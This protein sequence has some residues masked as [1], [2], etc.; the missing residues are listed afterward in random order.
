MSSKKSKFRVLAVHSDG[1]YTFF[2]R[3][4]LQ[5]C[6]FFIRKCLVNFYPEYGSVTYH[7]QEYRKSLNEYFPFITI[8]Y[9]H[10]D[11]PF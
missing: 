6:I 5:S 1:S 10:T 7:I 11:L 8:D 3:P 9:F 2:Y 4:T